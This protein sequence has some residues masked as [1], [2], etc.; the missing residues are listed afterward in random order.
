MNISFKDLCIL[1]KY[2]Y[3]RVNYNVF[4]EAMMTVYNDEDY[5]KPLWTQFRDNG[6]GFLVGRNEDKVFEYFINQIE[7]TNYKG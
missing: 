3:N 2:F 6:V 5:I 4:L 7:T 1:Q